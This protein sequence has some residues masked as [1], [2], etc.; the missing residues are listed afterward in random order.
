M[1][2]HERVNAVRKGNYFTKYGEVAQK[3]IDSLLVKYE[4]E[5]ITSIESASVLKLKPINELGSPVELVK[6]FG[7]KKDFEK[8][9]IELE[10][11]NIA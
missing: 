9:L 8:A 1:T 6:A 11:Y 5:G 7:K 10:I 3:V 2:R 4:K